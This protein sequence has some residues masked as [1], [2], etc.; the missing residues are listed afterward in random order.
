MSDSHSKIKKYLPIALSAWV[1][2]VFVQSLF[3]KFTDSPETQHIFGTIAQWMTEFSILKPLSSIFAQ[4]GG[5]AIGLV[6]LM[7]SA[8]LIHSIFTCSKNTRMLGALIGLGV[9]SGAIFF[10]LFTPLGIDVQDDGGTLFFMALTV[11]V[12]CAVLLKIGHKSQ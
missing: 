6:E 9:I 2:F 7:A 4:F 11:F 1:S 10:H 3:F 8:L 12:S 5:Y